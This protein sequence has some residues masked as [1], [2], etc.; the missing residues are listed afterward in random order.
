MRA[1]RLE[2]RIT[3]LRPVTTTNTFG[4]EVTEWATSVEADA[5]LVTYTGRLS[6]EVGE[7][8]ADYS[9]KWNIH[10]AHEVAEHWRVQDEDG[11]LYTVTN[12]IP[13]R[14]RGFKT[15]ICERVNE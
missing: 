5:E 7:H 8:F 10:E 9:T 2:Y 12:I 3:L 4:E 13:N 14:R 1:G 6:E 15:L 11:L